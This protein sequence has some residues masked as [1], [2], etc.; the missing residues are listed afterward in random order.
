MVTTTTETK[1]E[2]LTCCI[3]GH[4]GKD[5]NFHNVYIGGKGYVRRAEC[6]DMP[7]CSKRQDKNMEGKN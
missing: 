4:T 5:V 7:Q 6:D 1:T 3:C 2:Q